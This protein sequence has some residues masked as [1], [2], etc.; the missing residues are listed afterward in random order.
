MVIYF[1]TK[2]NK[3]VQ[4]LYI[5]NFKIFIFLTILFVIPK[6][7]VF[8]QVESIDNPRTW[9]YFKIFARAQDDSVFIKLQDG[10][11]IDRSLNLMS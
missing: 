3:Y 1:L 8:A 10:L 11:N 6:T 9:K 4:I 7:S 5:F 2:I